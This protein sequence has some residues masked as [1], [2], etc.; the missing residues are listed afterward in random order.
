[1]LFPRLFQMGKAL[2][3]SERAKNLLNAYKD[4]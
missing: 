1:M 3:T 2:G 4:E